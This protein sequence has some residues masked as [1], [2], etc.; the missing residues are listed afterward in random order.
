MNSFKI[1]L[2]LSGLGSILFLLFNLFFFHYHKNNKYTTFTLHPHKKIFG[3]KRYKYFSIL[4]NANELYSKFQGN[5][6]LNQIKNETM[7]IFFILKEENE[8]EKMKQILKY[9][10]QISISIIIS[11]NEIINNYM[12]IKSLIQK[13]PIL[14]NE[15]LKL[16]LL[17]KVSKKQ[18]KKNLLNILK[19]YSSSKKM[20]YFSNLNNLENK[21]MKLKL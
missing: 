6:K 20:I 8:I 17:F 19:E 18:N 3:V 12:Y 2:I 16:N 11:N 7:T 13:Y 15:K 9:D 21:I 4:P 1:L 14:K 5:F 10:I